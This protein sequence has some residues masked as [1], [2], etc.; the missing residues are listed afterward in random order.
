MNTK[1]VH[2][3]DVN[4]NHCVNTVI[5]E[6]SDLNG[7]SSISGDAESKSFTFEWNEPA[8]WEQISA[9]LDELGYPAD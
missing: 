6:I 7:V 5:R 9:E 1:T 8:S 3:S 2:I 4:C